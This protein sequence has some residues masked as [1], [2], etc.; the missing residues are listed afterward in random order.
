MIK[1]NKKDEIFLKS[2]TYLRRFGIISKRQR[3]E[4]SSIFRMPRPRKKKSLKDQINQ[5]VNQNYYDGEL[6]YK[7]TIFVVNH[8]TVFVISYP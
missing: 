1:Q 7:T 8:I 6:L 5:S 2:E 3:K 4:N